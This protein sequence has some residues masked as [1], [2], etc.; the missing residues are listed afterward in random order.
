V[1]GSEGEKWDHYWQ[2]HRYRRAGQVSKRVAHEFVWIIYP[3]LPELAVLPKAQQMEIWRECVKA[4]SPGPCFGWG[5]VPLWV[6]ALWLMAV[7]TFPMVHYRPLR[8]L[9]A[10]AWGAALGVVQQ[11]LRFQSSIPA[12][13]KRIGVLSLE[14]GQDDRWSAS[15]LMTAKHLRRHG[16][17]ESRT[18]TV[19]HRVS[20][21]RLLFV[22]SSPAHPRI[23][24]PGNLT[25][26][27]EWLQLGRH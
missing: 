17:T 19:R 7:T 6:G 3:Y 10:E 23:S 12:I 21:R 15:H 4:S 18:R 16:R 13:H 11:H 1:P 8:A 5:F 25:Y 14:G 27:R 24:G 26:A 20:F 9:I 2:R 22:T